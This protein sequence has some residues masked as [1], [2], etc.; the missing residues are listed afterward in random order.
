MSVRRLT[1]TTAAMGLLGWALTVLSPDPST[2]ATAF[3]APQRTVDSA[4]PDA[5]VLAGI[6]LLCWAAWLWGA[7][8]LALTAASAVPGVL[9]AAA[10][11]GVRLVLPAAARRVAAVTLGLGLGIGTPLLAPPPLAE[12]APPPV[13]VPDWPVSGSSPPAQP[14][15]D[16]PATSA[17]GTHVVNRGDCL[18]RVAEARLRQES[19]RSPRTADVAAAT[20][21]WWAANAAVIGPDPD[22]LLPGQVLSAPDHL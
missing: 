6:G 16:W 1:A 2:I 20:Q 22:L 10:R 17:P 11:A 4:G 15:P 21:A 9:G 19:G 3:V 13:T 14:A 18:W 5:L 12:A 7:L 8:G